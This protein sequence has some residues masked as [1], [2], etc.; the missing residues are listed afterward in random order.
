MTI[1]CNYVVDYICWRTPLKMTFGGSFS[2]LA[3]T[4]RTTVKLCLSP[5]HDKIRTVW[6]PVNSRVLMAG[7]SNRMGVSSMSKIWLNW[8]SWRL[9]ALN[10]NRWNSTIFS[11]MSAGRRC[12]KVV[13]ALIDTVWRRLQLFYHPID[14]L[15]SGL[16][17]NSFAFNRSIPLLTE[18]LAKNKTT[19]LK[20]KVFYVHVLHVNI[21][22]QRAR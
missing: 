17:L 11:S 22:F 14:A 20:H 5:P 9:W 4:A 2:P 7:S 10:T 12:A 21:F 6:F 3:L 19:V 1:I 13:F 18:R 15:N 16:E 8:W